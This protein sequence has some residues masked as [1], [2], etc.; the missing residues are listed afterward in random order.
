MPPGASTRRASAIARGLRHARARGSG[1]P[2]RTRRPGR[3][4]S[5]VGARQRRARCGR[6]PRPRI[7]ATPSAPVA[8]ARCQLRRRRPADHG[9]RPDASAFG[10][11][12]A[13]EPGLEIKLTGASRVAGLLVVRHGQRLD[14]LD[15]VALDTSQSS[16][17]TGIGSPSNRGAGA[18]R[19][20][21]AGRGGARGLLGFE[22]PHDHLVLAAE[23]LEPPRIRSGAPRFAR[24]HEIPDRQL[25]AHAAGIANLGVV[26][27][28]LGRRTEPAAAV[29]H[30]VHLARPTPATF[31]PCAHGRNAGRRT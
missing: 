3:Q 4:P 25:V 26:R 8:R 14:R 29:Q 21:R 23:A 5:R 16:A 13:K 11:R 17:P 28:V 30:R 24:G 31:T 18:R 7:D 15:D 1:R 6:A 12:L 10:E 27:A 9:R 19:A 20:P 2:R 22:R